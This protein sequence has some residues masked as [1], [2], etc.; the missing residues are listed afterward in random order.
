VIGSVA[1]SGTPRA[2]LAFGENPKPVE[3]AGRYAVILGK[4]NL[5]ARPPALLYDVERVENGR[6]DH[7]DPITAGRMVWRGEADLNVSDLLAGATTDRHRKRDDV[8]AWLRDVLADGP[9]PVI[10]LQAEAD[11]RGFGWRTVERAKAEVGV[12]AY[13]EGGVAGEGRWVWALT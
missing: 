10:D 2:V 12:E 1:W 6:D 13:R 9:V 8:A 4:S 3:H 5:G 7:G 11:E